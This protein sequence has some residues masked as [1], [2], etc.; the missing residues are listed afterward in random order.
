MGNSSATRI[1]ETLAALKSA[2]IRVNV[3]HAIAREEPPKV[4]R[5]IAPST[6]RPCRPAE[7]K[8]VG[9]LIPGRRGGTISGC[10]TGDVRH[11]HEGQWWIG[12]PVIGIGFSVRKSTAASRIR[13]LGKPRRADPREL[14]AQAAT[15]ALREAGTDHV[16]APTGL[17]FP[18]VVGSSRCDPEHRVWERFADAL[19][20]ARETGA[21]RAA[22]EVPDDATMREYERAADRLTAEALRAHPDWADWFATETQCARAWQSR[23]AARK[24]KAQFSSQRETAQRREAAKMA[25]VDLSSAEWR[26]TLRSAEH[27]PTKKGR[28]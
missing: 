8:R 1:L 5:K 14:V 20:S 2:G 28:R 10:A 21:E 19:Q 7:Q 11:P 18:H 6:P 13:N 4:A 15:L 9:T 3:R 24:P 17:E 25:R 16:P 12:L 23:E 26:D 27:K 22:M